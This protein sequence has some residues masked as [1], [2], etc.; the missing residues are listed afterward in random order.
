MMRERF[1]NRKYDVTAS[2]FKAETLLCTQVGHY[3]A[4]ADQIQCTRKQAVILREGSSSAGV[5]TN[6]TSFAAAG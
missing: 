4:V 1:A 3:Q 2:G 5:S 6:V